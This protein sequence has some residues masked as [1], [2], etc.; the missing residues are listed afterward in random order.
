MRNVGMCLTSWTQ[1][2]R[3]RSVTPGVEIA[4]AAAKVM[5]GLLTVRRTSWPVRAVVREEEGGRASDVKSEDE[6]V[7]ASRSSE[8]GAVRMSP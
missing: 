6:R 5:S 8:S 2:A 1:R 7:G 4:G 3:K